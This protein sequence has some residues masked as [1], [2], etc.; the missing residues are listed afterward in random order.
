L[1]IMHQGQGYQSVIVKSVL[2]FGQ[3]DL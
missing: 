3:Y 2:I 1:L